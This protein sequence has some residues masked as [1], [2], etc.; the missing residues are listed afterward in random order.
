MARSRARAPSHLP[1]LACLGLSQLAKS[2]WQ[3]TAAV[4][5]GRRSAVRPLAGA[6]QKSN[7]MFMSCYLILRVLLYSAARFISFH[8]LFAFFFSLFLFFFLVRFAFAFLFLFVWKYFTY[9][10]ISHRA[11]INSSNR[12]SW[13]S[14][15]ARCLLLPPPD[16]FSRVS[17]HTS[18]YDIYFYD[19]YLCVPLCLC[20][21]VPLFLYASVKSS[22][23]INLLFYCVYAACAALHDLWALTDARSADCDRITNEFK[24]WRLIDFNQ[25]NKELEILSFK[26]KFKWQKTPLK[27]KWKIKL[28]GSHSLRIC[29]CCANKRSK[30]N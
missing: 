25:S 1:C 24:A 6:K 3:A 14:L 28:N 26:S 22:W 19:R 11:L 13:R 17:S 21:C 8:L 16:F 29:S 20:L 10:D 12:T 15:R 5:D 23:N 2:A 18:F 7:V 9:T 27:I 30:R 4:G